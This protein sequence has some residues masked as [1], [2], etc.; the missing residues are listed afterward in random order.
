[1]GIADR[2]RQ[3]GDDFRAVASNPP[4][5]RGA[6]KIAL[7]C[8]QARGTLLVKEWCDAT[9]VDL[10]EG[11]RELLAEHT[12][13]R[14]WGE[15]ELRTFS[16]ASF[17]LLVWLHTAERL[18]APVDNPL[19]IRYHPQ[20]AEQEREGVRLGE[21]SGDDWPTRCRESAAV[22]Q[23]LADEIDKAGVTTE[24]DV[25][26]DADLGPLERALAL[27]VSHPT[28]TDTHIADVVGVHRG[29]LYKPTWSKYRN[30]RKALQEAAKGDI[31]H[32]SKDGKTGEMEAW[33]GD[34]F[35]DM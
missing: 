21:S 5:A 1:M 28:W 7:E 12:K 2:V 18:G 22:C 19:A 3:L 33:D 15:S 16:L 9:P 26:G 8:L 6:R 31:P 13:P 24:P 11:F 17:W 34:T 29:T 30:A 10:G 23:W 14:A 35:G 32:G 4:D 25:A 20:T 27:L